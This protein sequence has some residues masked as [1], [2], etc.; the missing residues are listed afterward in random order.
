MKYKD[1]RPMFRTGIGLLIASFVI[2]L[3]FL[4]LIYANSFFVLS[5]RDASFS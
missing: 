2:Q 1:T 4:I 5:R 3:V